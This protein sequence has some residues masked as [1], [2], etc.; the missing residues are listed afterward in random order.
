MTCSRLPGALPRLGR[1]IVE[2][3]DEGWTTFMARGR[4]DHRN[5]SQSS[6]DE[7][8]LFLFFFSAVFR[9]SSITMTCSRLPGA[10]PRLGRGIVE[11][12]DEGWVCQLLL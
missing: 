8:W 9:L 4:R 5:T 6:D 11:R 7:L 3:D 12:D 1:G 10:L 2:R